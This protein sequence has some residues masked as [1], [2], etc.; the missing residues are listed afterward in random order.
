MYKWI[1]AIRQLTDNL[2]VIFTINKINLTKSK[3]FQLFV[4]I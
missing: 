2:L 1:S 4:N 3:K